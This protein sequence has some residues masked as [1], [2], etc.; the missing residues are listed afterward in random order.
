MAGMHGTRGLYAPVRSMEEKRN[1]ISISISI[2]INIKKGGY[3]QHTYIIHT[4]T[5]KSIN[6]A[7]ISA[8]NQRY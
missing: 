2:N 4:D 3:I 1:G 5:H 7:G 8:E 6:T